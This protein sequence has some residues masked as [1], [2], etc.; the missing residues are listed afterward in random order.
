[1]SFEAG[2]ATALHCV[3][4]WRV[5]RHQDGRTKVALSLEHARRLLAEQGDESP[6]ID[7]QIEPELATALE[8]YLA[9]DPSDR[10]GLGAATLDTIK[11]LGL[12]YTAADICE[13]FGCDGA[14]LQLYFE[15]QR[16]SSA[17]TPARSTDSD[18][19]CG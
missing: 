11:S 18:R 19:Q 10:E 16:R 3:D 12:S 13:L 4:H 15:R 14:E 7:I 6:R 1:M 8:A 5:R 17:A 9:S 2:T